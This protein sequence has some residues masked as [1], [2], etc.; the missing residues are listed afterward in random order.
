MIA[1]HSL[2]KFTRNFW[3]TILAIVVFS[4]SFAIYVQAEKQVDIAN[5]QRFAA[6]ALGN[7]MRQ[8]S[9]DLTRMA[10]AY[11][12]SGNSIFRQYYDEILAIRDGRAER[13]LNY[14]EIY[15]DLVLSD[16]QRPR[17]SSGKKFTFEELMQQAKISTAEKEKLTQELIEHGCRR[18][19]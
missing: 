2:T 9:D 19:N 11:V 18:K 3:L 4:V 14:H 10:R 15:W 13:P 12:T 6:L 1:V 16:N 17:P 5:D 8:S 7:E